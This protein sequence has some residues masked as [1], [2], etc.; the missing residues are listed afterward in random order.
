MRFQAGE[1]VVF[2]QDFAVASR[3]L[4]VLGIKPGKSERHFK[5]VTRRIPSPHIPALVLYVYKKVL[6]K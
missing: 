4:V 5:I 1:R 3:D 6:S 2:L